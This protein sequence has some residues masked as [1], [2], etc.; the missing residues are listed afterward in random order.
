MIHSSFINAALQGK[1]EFWRYLVGLIIIFIFSSIIGAI[2]ALIVFMTSNDPTAAME[3]D[4]ETAGI[5]ETLGFALLL[6]SFAIG[7]IGVWITL[8]NLHYRPFVSTINPK[9]KINWKKVLV[10]AGIW[11]G[12]TLVLEGYSYYTTPEVYEWTFDFSRFLPMFI[13]AIILIPL[14]TSFEEIVFRGYLMQGL[15]LA[16]RYPIIPLLIT[17]AVFGAMHLANPE[18]AEY[19][20]WI[21]WTYVGIGLMLGLVTLMDEG[22]ELALGVHA[23]NNLYACIFVTFPS[24]ALSTPA[25]F[26]MT[27]FDAVQ[28]SILG[29]IAQVAFVIICAIIYKWDNFGKLFSKVVLKNPM[30]ERQESE[31]I[32]DFVLREE[33]NIIDS[34]QLNSDT[35]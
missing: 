9:N 13:V 33:N 17:S 15:G 21:I 31:G 8:K 35:E 11:F 25:M 19:G 1:N 20:T 6:L 24:S 4:F 2:P 22:L 10:G 12:L 3:M 7:L 5:N 29:T 27:E 26:T 32:A 28:S 14:Q 30:N 34:N 18:I 23:M 16:F